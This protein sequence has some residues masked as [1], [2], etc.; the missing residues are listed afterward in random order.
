MS[1]SAILPRMTA[2]PRIAIVGP[3]SLGSALG[4]SL[5]KAGYRISEVLSREGKKSRRRASRLARAVGA[6]AATTDHPNLTA[7][8]V[9]P[10][11]PDP[12]IEPCAQSF[13]VASSGQGQ[14]ALHPT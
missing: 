2:K 8:I 11:V 13:Q 3:G 6:R 1:N 9:R 7:Q 12:E 4:V 5:R 10:C 14:V